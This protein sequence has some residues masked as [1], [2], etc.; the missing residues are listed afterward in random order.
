MYDMATSRSCGLLQEAEQP[1]GTNTVVQVNLRHLFTDL[2]RP[3]SARQRV[4]ASRSGDLSM[5][6]S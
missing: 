6:N 3:Q 1:L 2:S 4:L 5:A